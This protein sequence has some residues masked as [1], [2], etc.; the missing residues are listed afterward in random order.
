MALAPTK[1]QQHPRDTLLSHTPSM[2]TGDIWQTQLCTEP[3]PQQVAGWQ[4]A[5]ELRQRQ[6]VSPLA[7][8]AAVAA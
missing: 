1:T 8:A 7:A 6:Q 4:V 2:Y 3:N 5:A